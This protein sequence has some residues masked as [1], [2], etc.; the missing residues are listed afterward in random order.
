MIYLDMTANKLPTRNW[1]TYLI[2]KHW[3]QT[4]WC[5]VVLLLI[6]YGCTHISNFESSV[7]HLNQSPKLKTYFNLFQCCEVSQNILPRNMQEFIGSREI[8]SYTFQNTWIYKL[9]WLKLLF[10]SL[11][12][13][14][15][16]AIQII[17]FC[18]SAPYMSFN[19]QKWYFWSYTVLNY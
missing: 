2:W 4:W 3:M 12:K 7:V 13:S 16:G 9:L 18:P 5:K 11:T 8:Q 1:T 15:L 10:Y 14:L 19:F 6:F 17:R